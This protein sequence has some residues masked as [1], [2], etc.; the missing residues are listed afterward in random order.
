MRHVHVADRAAYA[1]AV[2]LLNDHGEWAEAEA[3]R[4]ARAGRDLGNLIT[5][6]HW[7]QIGRTVAMLR[8]PEVVGS[9][10]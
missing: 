9:V 3:A 5:F 8:S 7:R 1:A 6:C 10:H 2:R 4:L